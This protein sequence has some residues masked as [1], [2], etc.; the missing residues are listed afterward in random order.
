MKNLKIL[1]N[2]SFFVLVLLFGFGFEAQAYRIDN[3][4]NI[5][6]SNDFVLGGGKVELFLNPGDNYAK[7]LLITN[8]L[9]KPMNFKVG[10]EDFTGS[11]NIEE[12]IVL[13]GDKKGPYSLKDYLKPEISE[14]VLEH[15]QRMVLPVEIS[16][17]PNAEPGG[18]Y[19]TV[20]VS[21]HPL[22]GEIET[23]QDKAKGQIGLITRLG[24][25]FFVKIK[26]ETK[27][28][29]LMKD[30]KVLKDFYEKGPVFFQIL[31]ENNG[32]VHLA[33]SGIIEIRNIF[34]KKVDEIA[35]DRYFAMPDA[36]KF[37]EVKWEKELLFGR[38]TASII[39]NRGYG[40][41]TDK[42]S[43]SFW[44]LPWK[45]VL[46]VLLIL[47][48]AIGIVRWILKNFEFKRKGA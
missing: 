32:N 7:E 45:I 9:G 10:V 43:V 48:A 23:E 44:F 19:G 46:S 3:M 24:C 18:L 36:M 42:K 16:I 4:K 2:S 1:L 37:R 21:A 27:E 13:L 30:F 31:F 35:V 34:G 5:P 20:L 38:Y 22:R 29:G 47:F 17:P 11:Q 41:L 14:F 6:I 33:P 26:G 39:L 12:S 40:N 28:D 15:G 25:L 8:R